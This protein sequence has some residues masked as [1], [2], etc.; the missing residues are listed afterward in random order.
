MV[1]KRRLN[2]LA[3]LKGALPATRPYPSVDEI[4][5]EVGEKMGLQKLLEFYSAKRLAE[6]LLSN[7]VDAKDYE[8]A[9]EQERSLGVDPDSIPHV[10]PR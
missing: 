8:R 1:S 9:V 6:L 10:K 7:A 3:D 5:R 2:K 4:R